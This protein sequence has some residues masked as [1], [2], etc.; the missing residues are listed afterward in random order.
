MP[1]KKKIDAKKLIEMVTKGTEQKEI[2]KKFGFKNSTQ[3]KVAYANALMEQGKAPEIKSGAK[4]KATS[5]G[6]NEIKVNKRG[7]LIVPGP[8]V[9]AMGFKQGDSFQIRKTKAGVSLKK[10]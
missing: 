9:Q 10:A 1:R 2:M 6:K 7:S 3:L 5:K 8:M 4:A